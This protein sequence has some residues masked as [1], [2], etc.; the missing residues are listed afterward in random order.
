MRHYAC[1]ANFLFQAVQLVITIPHIL[2]L[3]KKKR[4]E[5]P[6][7]WLTAKSATIELS[8]ITL[9]LF[10]G[11]A[12]RIELRLRGP[13]PLVLPLNYAH[14]NGGEHWTCTRPQKGRQS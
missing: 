2:V 1:N 4:V 9:H 7:A 12:P 13:Q 5:P 10:M 14:Y 11:Y 3:L 6:T 8:T